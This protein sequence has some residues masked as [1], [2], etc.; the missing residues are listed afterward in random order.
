MSDVFRPAYYTIAPMSDSYAECNYGTASADPVTPC[1]FKVDLNKCAQNDYGFAVNK[2]CLF[3]KPNKV[4]YKLH[5]H[6][7]KKLGIFPTSRPQLIIQIDTLLLCRL[8]KRSSVGLQFPTQRK[9]S[10]QKNFKCQPIWRQ[11][12]SNFQLMW[13]IMSNEKH[14]GKLFSRLK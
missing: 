3:L 9:K 12:F 10:N 2:P 6:A 4:R 7:R 8:M 14:V 13:Y 1:S 5:H 11:P